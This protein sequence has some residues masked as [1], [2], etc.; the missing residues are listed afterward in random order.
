MN[1]S[2]SV[3]KYDT[4]LTSLSVTL[5]EK[6]LLSVLYETAKI[7]VVTVK[8]KAVCRDLSPR[9]ETVNYKRAC[10]DV[11]IFLKIIRICDENI[12]KNKYL[13]Q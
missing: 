6:A 13:K 11:V 8:G 4:L 1:K 12:V 9:A 5:A 3:G 10:H 7:D 2:I